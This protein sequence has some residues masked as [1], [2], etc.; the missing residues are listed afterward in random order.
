M[1]WFKKL[2]CF[3][4]ILSALT[5]SGETAYA[6]NVFKLDFAKTPTKFGD[7]VQKQ[8]DNFQ[9]AMKEIG[10][11]QF[12]TFIGDGIKAAKKG[13]A[14]AKEKMEEVKTFIKKV[15]DTVD[16][17]KN[18]TE[19]KIAM[20]SVEAAT[21]AATLDTIKK[22]RDK[23]KAEKKSEFEVQKVTLNE[24]LE[25]AKENYNVGLEIL[26]GELEALEDKDAIQFKR[27]E[28]ANFEK[29]SNE[30]IAQIE[31]EIS[32][33]EEAS[34]EEIKAIELNFATAIVAQ[35]TVIAGIGIEIAELVA[36]KKREK[37]EMEKDPTKVMEEAANDF[38]YKEGEVVT[39]EARQ[40]KEKTRRRKR[41]S[42]ST[43][44][45]GLSSSIVSKTENKKTEEQQNS[46]MSGTMNGKSEALQT[47]TS[48]TIVQMDSLYEYLL[49]EL[50]A[51]ELETSN[52]LSENKEYKANKVDSTIDICNY[53]MDKGSF[54]DKLKNAKDKVSGAVDKAKGAIDTAK[55][56]IDT[57]KG[58]IDTAK[59]AIDTATGAVE[60]LS[61]NPEDMISGLTGM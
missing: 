5:F 3:L 25:E 6:Q 7:W 58:A 34:K 12:A 56:A 33:L 42:A 37:G 39:I 46:E 59:G 43:A 41:A 50:K 9:N 15:K 23:Q 35:T 53:Q 20:L 22:D 40:K 10:E 61:E 16:A 24:K 44:A 51:I 54:L 26:N 38:S 19:Y 1:S 36:Q 2:S 52:L 31:A 8:A 29:T 47:A 49:L 60:G 17:V 14:F 48:Q 30:T 21:Q 28:I 57:A 13:L 18:S 32:Q 45:S 11:S 4:I 55:G 27:D